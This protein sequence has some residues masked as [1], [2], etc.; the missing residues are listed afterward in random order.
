MTTKTELVLEAKG[1]RNI[2]AR[3][4]VKRQGKEII[5]SFSTCVEFKFKREGI[6]DFSKEDMLKLSTKEFEKLR[7]LMK[8]EECQTKKE[9]NQMPT[10]PQKS[11]S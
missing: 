2:P 1:I 5:M 9:E 7:E 6:K 4:R 3:I 11:S 8:E 10:K